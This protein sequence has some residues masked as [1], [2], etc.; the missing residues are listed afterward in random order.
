M[1]LKDKVAIVTGVDAGSIGQA[2]A[3][4]L[5]EAGVT[6]VVVGGRAQDGTETVALIRKGG[7]N[8]LLLNLDIAKE[9]DAK[10]ACEDTVRDFGRLDILVNNDAVFVPR[11]LEPPDED[12]QNSSKVIGGAALI[13]RYAAE[14]MKRQEKGAIVNIVTLSGPRPQSTTYS[15]TSATLM[16]MT[17]DMAVDLAPDNIRV[18]CV[19]HGNVRSVTSVENTGTADQTEKEP[20]AVEGPKHLLSRTGKPREVAY[21][22]LFLASDEASF[23]TGTHLFV[24]GGHYSTAKSSFPQHFA[25]KVASFS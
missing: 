24:D 15:T 1:R 25:S 10:Q 21:A 3:L 18:N 13:S 22:I 6:V 19:C 11:G 8:A 23:I 9:R 20:L 14:A 2:T 17:R 16:Q 4:I 12:W 5:A 7:G